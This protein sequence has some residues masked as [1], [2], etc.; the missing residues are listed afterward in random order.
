MTDTTSTRIVAASLSTGIAVILLLVL[1][2]FPGATESVVAGS[3][4]LGSGCGWA[5]LAVLS[6]RRTGRPQAWLAVPALT[7]GVAGLA[8]VVLAPGEPVMTRLSW[9]WPPVMLGLGGWAFLRIRRGIS[10]RGRWLLVSVLAILS[11]AS[12]G[13]V[14]ANLAEAQ[15]R[16]DFPAPGSTYDVEGRQMHLWCQGQ[17]SPTVVLFGGLGE[18]ST[19]WTHIAEGVRSTTR[20]CAYDRAGQAWSEDAGAPETGRQ[21]ADDLHA[22]LSAAG[23][24]G[25]FVLAGHSI[26]GPYAMVYAE[27]Y[28]DE[29]AGMVLLDSSSPEQMTAIPA[30]PAQ[31]AL[32]RRGLAVLPTLARIG[33]GPLF[34]TGSGL[35]GVAADETLAMTGTARALRNGRDEI[36]M[37][38]R[39]FEQAQALTSLEDRPLVVLTAS[40]SLEM[41]GWQAAQDT[42]AR[43]STDHVARTV[44]SSH[45]GM[46]ADPRVA[47][48]S[49]DAITAVVASI[50]TGQPLR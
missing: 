44:E 45:E 46:V 29:V 3:I 21:A 6:G 34:A 23:E 11:V 30:Y 20:V 1:G 13:A 47:A 9:V 12:V 28:P 38:P 37:V 49:A 4:L 36:A 41:E 31:Y 32:M 25:P 5:M 50:R 18:I 15:V 43:L 39:I 14:Y 24:E 48:Q 35:P 26:G 19:S 17:G 16:D 22:L 2:V 8:L 7:M 10:G 40:E 33:L 27:R 42:L